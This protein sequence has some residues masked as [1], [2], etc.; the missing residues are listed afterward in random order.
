MK[1]SNIPVSEIVFVLSCLLALAV[2]PWLVE[3]LA[4]VV[5]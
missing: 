4:R 2:V 3:T 5:S 1:P